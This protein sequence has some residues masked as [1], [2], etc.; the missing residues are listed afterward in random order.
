MLGFS[1]IFWIVVIMG[2]ILNAVSFQKVPLET[3][4]LRAYYFSPSVDSTYYIPGLYN[5]GVG[6]YFI[7]FPSSKQY[8]IDSRVQVIN[9][10]L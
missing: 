4:G 2:V 6:Y 10:N 7:T 3:Y 8:V 9:K 5:V 1:I